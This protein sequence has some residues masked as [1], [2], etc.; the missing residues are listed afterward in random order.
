MTAP[1]AE[2]V[3]EFIAEAKPLLALARQHDLLVTGGWGVGADLIGWVY[4]LERMVYLTYD[5]PT[6][7]AE[8]LDIIAQWNPRGY[9]WCS[10]RGWTCTST[11][12]V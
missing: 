6:F 11:R 3:A 9:A 10:A 5:R 4:G 1:T 12:V 2:E 7:L 8:M